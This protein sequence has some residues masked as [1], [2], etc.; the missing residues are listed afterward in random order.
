MQGG[1]RMTCE[2]CGEATNLD[3]DC[4]AG[5]GDGQVSQKQKLVRRC[6]MKK[7][8][9]HSCSIFRAFFLMW[10]WGLKKQRISKYGYYFWADDRGFCRIRKDVYPNKIF[11]GWQYLYGGTLAGQKR[12]EGYRT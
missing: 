1:E 4:K 3:G 12:G 11:T 2:K 10:K 5:C 7:K 6:G 8:G 9:W